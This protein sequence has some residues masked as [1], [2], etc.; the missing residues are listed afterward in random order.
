MIP[1][2]PTRPE[3]ALYNANMKGFYWL[4]RG[5]SLFLTSGADNQKFYRPYNAIM[6]AQAE[7]HSR[8]SRNE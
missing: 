2:M 7:G 5:G 3:I 1:I 4:K 8:V 6:K